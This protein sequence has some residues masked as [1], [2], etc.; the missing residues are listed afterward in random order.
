MAFL[1]QA[2]DFDIGPSDDYLVIDE[3]SYNGDE[4]PDALFTPSELTPKMKAR[5]D[6]DDT[7]VTR[8]SGNSTLSQEEEGEESQKESIRIPSPATL[9][10]KGSLKAFNIDEIPVS[11]RKGSWKSLPKPDM[12]K[13]KA[14]EVKRTESTSSFFHHSPVASPKINRSSSKVNFQNVTIR[15]Y[16]VT[17][18]DNPSVSYGPPLSLDWTYSENDSMCVNEYEGSRNQR[19]TP[20]QMCVNYFQR[21]NILSTVGHTEE[22]IK[23]AKK[24]VKKTKNQRA[25]TRQFLPLLK[26]EDAVTSA[27]RKAK[28]I[29]GVGKKKNQNTIIS[30]TTPATDQDIMHP[31]C[32]G[33]L[34]EVEN[35]PSF[36]QRCASAPVI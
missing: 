2:H 23:Q 31:S 35:N 11:T 27:G 13:I 24:E 12:E 6:S 5:M 34:K 25:M 7:A 9:P 29:M 30:N 15:E 33:S 19:R 4:S 26:V 22:E 1:A 3:D 20:R 8:M 10:R 14:T 16:D 28:R 21:V 36:I 17:L 32:T 18:G